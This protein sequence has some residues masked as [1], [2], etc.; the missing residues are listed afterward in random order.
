V[1]IKSYSKK[2]GLVVF[3]GLQPLFKPAFHDTDTD[4]LARIVARMSTC[5][6]ACHRNEADRPLTRDTLNAPWLLTDNSNGLVMVIHN[7][8]WL[9]SASRVI[10]STCSAPLVQTGERKQFSLL[11]PDLWPTTLTYNPRLT[12]VKVDRHAK[13]QGQRSNGSNRQTDEHTDA[14]KRIIAPAIRGR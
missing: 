5:R 11:D 14:T 12:K 2:C 9:N 4:I 13:N 1:A 10:I 6:S 8:H 7:Y 3:V